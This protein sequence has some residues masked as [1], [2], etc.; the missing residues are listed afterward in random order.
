MKN[1]AEKQQFVIQEHKTATGVHWDMMLENEGKLWTW[2]IEIHPSKIADEP[3]TAER[4]F[5]HSLRF[6]TYEGPVQN[7]TASVAI[8]DK[9]SLCFR[10]TNDQKITFEF[11]GKILTGPYLLLLRKSPLWTLQKD[12]T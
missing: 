9:G 11:Y 6:L 2:R 3:V 5:D 4:I 7:N 8:V 12:K 1:L 10:Q